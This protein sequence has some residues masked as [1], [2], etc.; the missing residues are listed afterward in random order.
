MGSSDHEA[1]DVSPSRGA[2]SHSGRSAVGGGL[3]LRAIMWGAWG[4]SS[5]RRWKLRE[6]FLQVTVSLLTLK[7]VTEFTK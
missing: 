3:G 7:S 2:H 5:R 6:S 1:R 4:A